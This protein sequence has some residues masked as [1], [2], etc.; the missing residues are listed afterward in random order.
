LE[1]EQLAVAINTARQGNDEEERAALPDR[2][3]QLA[4]LDRKIGVLLPPGDLGAYDVLK[5][6]DIEQ[7]QLQDYAGGIEGVAPLSDS[8][9]QSIL[10]TKLVYRQRFRRVLDESRLMG[11]E[12]GAAERRAAF[13]E[14]SR[15]LRDYQA[16]YLQE[17]RQ[18]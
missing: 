7:F 10:Y 6:S 8:D 5:D 18:Y 11:G 4:A 17:V 9:K 3:A 15:A 16:S 14:V 2:I 12:L 1:R 13:A